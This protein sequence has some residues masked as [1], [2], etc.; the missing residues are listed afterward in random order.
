MRQRR[1]DFWEK[2]RRALGLGDRKEVAAALGISWRALYRYEFE[3]PP[4]WY[5]LALVGLWNYRQ[6]KAE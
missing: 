1:G 6:V 2:R 4:A 5:D 3:N